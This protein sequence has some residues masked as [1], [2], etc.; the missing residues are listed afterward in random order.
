MKYKLTSQNGQALLLAIF[1]V[2]IISTLLIALINLV[3]TGKKAAYLQFEVMQAGYIADAGLEKL[4]ARLKYDMKW[5][6]LQSIATSYAGGS[7]IGLVINTESSIGYLELISTGS[8]RNSQ[9]TL[10][11]KVNITPAAVFNTYNSSITAHCDSAKNIAENI[12]LSPVQ[13]NDSDKNAFK[14]LAVSYGNDHYI[15]GDKV[16]NGTKLQNISGLYYV[17]GN[18]HVS[19]NY[20]GRA[21]IVATGDIY[22]DASLTTPSLTSNCLALICYHNINLKLS[23]LETVI[24]A[25]LWS[26]G[27]LNIFNN[28]RVLGAVMSSGIY[29][30]G[31]TLNYQFSEDLVNQMPPGLPVLTNIIYWKEKYPVF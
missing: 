29:L 18:V 6:N 28:A 23:A 20:S 11:A 9:K 10:T 17:E 1:V 14:T 16:F 22:I 7:I 8:F 25:V 2:V 19:G 30:N 27:S 3:G 24:N 5:N 15:S 21:T 31:N 13:I 26:E 12:S 4:L